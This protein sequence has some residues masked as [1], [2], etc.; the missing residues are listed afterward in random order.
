MTRNDRLIVFILRFLGT[1]ALFALVAVFMPMSW[2]A[3]VH[4]RMGLGEMPTDPIVEYMARSLSALYF[5]FGVLCLLAS[6]DVNH[7]RSLVKILA[8]TFLLMGVLFVWIDWSTGM[9]WLW[10]LC[11]GPP[12]IVL[13]TVLL[14]LARPNR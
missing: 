1:C 2:M 12:Q 4:V 5:F 8:A 6:S 14:F 9:P 10:S 3:A 13:G 11:E 7:H